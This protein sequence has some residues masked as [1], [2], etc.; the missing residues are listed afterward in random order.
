[1]CVYYTALDSL[2]EG[3]KTTL[4]KDASQGLNEE[5]IKKALEHIKREGG[6]II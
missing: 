5:A 6:Q 3:F 1:V 4:I 2:K